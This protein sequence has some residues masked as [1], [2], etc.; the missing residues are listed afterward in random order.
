MTKKD[1]VVIAE[2]L[3]KAEPSDVENEQGTM[4]EGWVKS[5]KFVALALGRENE[6]FNVDK[7]LKASGIIIN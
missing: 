2:A 1:Y 3:K 5:I 7:F 4:L 6:K